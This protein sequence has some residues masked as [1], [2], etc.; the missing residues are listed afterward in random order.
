MID[1]AD[2]EM[3]RTVTRVTPAAIRSSTSVDAPPPTSM[4]PALVAPTSRISRSDSAR[5]GL[6][7]SWLRRALQR[8]PLRARKDDAQDQSRHAEQPGADEEQCVAL[9]QGATGRERFNHHAGE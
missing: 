1:M 5:C 6:P 9:E 4:M 7:L 3:S 2:S 8:L